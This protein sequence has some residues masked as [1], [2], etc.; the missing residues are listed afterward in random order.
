MELQLRRLAESVDMTIAY[1]YQNW[2][3]DALDLYMRNRTW[4]MLPY[5]WIHYELRP[6][7]SPNLWW[8]CDDV[9]YIGIEASFFF[10]QQARN[11]V[12]TYLAAFEVWP[13]CEH[14]SRL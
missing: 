3:G 5:E 10:K 2:K 9:T 4:G 14:C 13:A 1:V 6:Y 11:F 7:S 12:I 8:D